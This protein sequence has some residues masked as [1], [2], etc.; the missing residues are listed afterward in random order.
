MHIN[1]AT[2]YALRT[3]VR[4]AVA[5]QRVRSVPSL[6]RDT[7]IAVR[8]LSKVCS[9]LVRGGIL[10]SIKGGKGGVVLGRSAASIS[11][12]DVVAAVSDDPR[13]MECVGPDAHCVRLSI[14]GLRPTFERAQQAIEAEL[15]RTTLDE[16][17]RQ[18]RAFKSWPRAKRPPPDAGASPA[19]CPGPAHGRA[20]ST[21]DDAR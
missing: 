8:F 18:T 7:G 2:E 11:V 12:W 10:V 6:A 21:G 15:K 20:P 5:P 19:S 1:W 4:L 14:C 9:R 17:A 3:M 13:V 16:V